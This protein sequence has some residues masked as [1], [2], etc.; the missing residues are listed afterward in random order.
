MLE[1]REY[2]LP[3]RSFRQKPEYRKFM[4]ALERMLG[5]LE[6]ENQEQ[7]PM[8]FIVLYGKKPRSNQ[9]YVSGYNRNMFTLEE[10]IQVSIFRR[11]VDN[12]LAR[13]YPQ[14]DLCGQTFILE[15][16]FGQNPYAG[17]PEIAGSSQGSKGDALQARPIAPRFS[18]SQMILARTQED[19]LRELVALVRLRGKIYEDW[20]FA[21]IDP[22]PRAVIN[23]SGPAGTGKTM[24]AHAL[25]HEFCVPILALNYA[26]IESKYVGDAPKNLM[27]AFDMAAE[28][29][30]LLF[31][32]EADSF[33][34]RRISAVTQ[35]ADQ[36]INS[37]RSQLL[38]LLEDFGGVVVFATNLP[39]NY[40]PAFLSRILRHIRFELPDRETRVRLIRKLIPQKAPRLEGEFNDDDVA[41]LA[42]ISDGFSGRDIKKAV[43]NGL[44]ASAMRHDH[45]LFE[46]ARRAFEEVASGLA[47]FTNAPRGYTM[48]A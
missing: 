18:F 26:D 7:V 20:G 6:L 8:H 28:H 23:F 33:L 48:P 32:D 21:E 5:R 41:L 38:M 46:D 44:T 19:A 29:G 36:A 31:F 16:R 17:Q 45:F 27:A 15:L 25:A 37:L 4:A 30:A 47:P 22:V 24:A 12:F 2:G 35:S 9:L 39:G 40:D 14:A 10:D 42:S 43:L 1:I 11:E 34:G 3:A 13:D